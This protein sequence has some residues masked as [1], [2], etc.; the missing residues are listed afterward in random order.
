[1]VK[2]AHNVAAVV[3]QLPL[4][5]LFGHTRNVARVLRMLHPSW[6]PTYGDNS[7]RHKCLHSRQ[8]SGFR[9]RLVTA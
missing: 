3:T 7:R 5:D 9:S 6:A 4:G 8:R 2:L 1:L